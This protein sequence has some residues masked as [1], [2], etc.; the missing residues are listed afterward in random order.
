[1]KKAYAPWLDTSW[2]T[3]NLD[4]FDRFHIDLD[5]IMRRSER[6]IRLISREKRKRSGVRKAQSRKN[7]TRGKFRDEAL[8]EL[9]SRLI[10]AWRKAGGR[11]GAGKTGP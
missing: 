9:C 4:R 7:S 1:M 2:R 6:C 8:I 3:E 11:V 5:R 10:D